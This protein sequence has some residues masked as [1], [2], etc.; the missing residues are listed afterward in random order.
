MALQRWMV[1]A[2]GVLCGAGVA[3]FGAP[4]SACSLPTCEP[5]VRLAP[6]PYLP[7]N[8]VYFQVVA[9]I[10]P[11]DLVLRTAEGEPIAASIRTIGSDRVF[12]PEQP[13]AEGT[14]VVLEYSTV[15][16]GEP[17][18]RTYEFTTTAAATIELVPAQLDVE[19]SGVKGPG[20]NDEA[21]FVRVRHLSGDATGDASAL[22]VHSYSIDGVPTG[23]REVGGQL[24]IE[25]PV[26][27]RPAVSTRQ[28][29]TCGNLYAAPPGVH[30]V[31]VSTHIIGADTQPEPVRLAVDVQCPDADADEPSDDGQTAAPDPTPDI[32]APMA[33]PSDFT[34]R[35]DDESDIPRIDDPALAPPLQSSASSCSLGSNGSGTGGSLLLACIGALGMAR[36]RRRRV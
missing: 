23:L 3:S 32:G 16:F 24:L 4:A 26:P 13:I 2:L 9:Q 33:S 8:L 31:E 5:P 29:D 15:C 36:V 1:G 25:V 17:A 14:S 35:D 11:T 6:L 28:I 7:G 18:Q 21:A 10:E 34:P 22:M 30:S 20:R 19:E 27:C 12:A